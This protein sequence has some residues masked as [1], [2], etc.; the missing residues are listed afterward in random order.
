MAVYRKTQ[1]SLGNYDAKFLGP[2]TARQSIWMGIGIVPAAFLG[3]NEYLVGLDIGVV[4]L[5]VV[6]VMIIPLFMAF[7]EKITYGMK[8]EDFAKQFYQYRI[9]APK[10][11]LYKTET[12]DDVMYKQKQKEE[13][14]E[15]GAE[16]GAKSKGT[17]VV[18]TKGKF[19][20]YEHKKSKTYQEYL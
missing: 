16:K 3:Y 4:F 11:R 2:F 8:P 6:L 17:K 12:Y 7:G 20:E 1:R 9:A 19:K 15:K 18:R 10:V 13:A 5:T 14:A